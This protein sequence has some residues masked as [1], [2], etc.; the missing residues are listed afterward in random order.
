M[1]DLT[2]REQCERRLDGMKGVRKPFE[3]DW[4]EIARLALPGRSDFLGDRRAANHNRRRANTATH[5][6]HGRRAART[7]AYGMQSGLS[8]SSMPWFKLKTTDPEL[9]EFQA[10]K[11]WLAQVETAIYGLFA[12]MGIYDAF[13]IGYSELGCFGVS[14]TV[15]L[16][17]MEYD[18]VAH[19]LTAGEYWIA[20]DDGLRTDT[21]YRQVNLTVAQVMAGFD[22]DKI[23]TQVKRAYDKSNLQTIVPVIHAIE[24]NRDYDPTKM[25]SDTKRYRS[26]WW[27]EKCDK[28]QGVLRS[29]GYDGK[30]FWAPRWETVGNDVY[31]D[32]APGFDALPD[33][34]EMQ[35]AAR[36]QGRAMD[37]LVKPPMKAPSGLSSTVMSLDPGSFTFAS[38]NDL[39]GLEPIFRP[40]YQTLNAIRES[41]A[42][43]RQDVSSCFYA[44]LFRSISD[45]EGVQPRNDLE[46]SLRNDEKY[47]QL[48][49]VVDRV[50]IEQL[51]VAVERAY[52]IL[53]NRNMIPAPPPDLEG[54]GLVIE[55]V[56][57]LAQAQRASQNTAIERAA[58]FVG[59]VAGLFPDAG[60]KFDAEQAIDEF[61]AGTGTPPKIIRSDEVVEQMKAQMQQQAQMAQMAE[62]APALRDGAQAAELLSRT[63]VQGG[64]T[65]L[66]QITG[67]PA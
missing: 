53:Q 4:A 48:G 2:I 61:A 20:T 44:D 37:M 8:P 21:L 50:N 56:S 60:I 62:M 36:R 5:D 67:L 51:E 13:K 41:R 3:T 55:F 65:M 24:R 7:L 27:E 1:A 54:R 58:R 10:V 14:A 22:Q 47:T 45:M 11:E 52:T 49:P 30:P 26:V 57:M 9:V 42:E 66:D 23:S 6:S 46:M 18:A 34:R 63:N 43:I 19:P 16:E 40:D 59:F 15:M 38:A 33:L 39:Q 12:D 64:Q 35:L 29:S 31:S 25:S 28:E 32:C 17:H